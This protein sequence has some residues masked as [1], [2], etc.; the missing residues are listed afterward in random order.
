MTGQPV[1]VVIVDDSQY[2]RRMFEQFLSADPAIEVVGSAADPLEARELI[3]AT[4]PDVV[5]LDVEMP[6][7]DGLSFLKK[8]MALRP[9]PVV[10]VSSLTQ[11]GAETTLKALEAGAVDYIGKP[12]TAKEL[13][14]IRS[15]L[16][17]KVKTAARVDVRAKARKAATAAPP[18]TLSYTGDASKWLIAIGASTGG[19]EAIREI[20]EAMPAM[21]PPMIITQHMPPMFT[22]SFAKRLNGLVAPTV[23]EAKEGQP[24][25]PGHVYIAPGAHH[26]SL[27]KQAGG[28]VCRL[29]D[30]P[31]VSGHKPS[32]DVMF[33]AVAET[34][35][36]RAVAAIL[37]GMGRDGAAGITKLHALGV[38]TLG[39]N[40]ASC[41]VY[42]MPRAAQ[43]MGGLRKELHLDRIAA[44]LLSL[45]A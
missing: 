11:K 33:E 3:K 9:M 30:R 45:C 13:E 43:A 2:I 5:T 8:I 19:V 37:T 35:P 41:I 32:V 6:K 1:K 44:E 42:G 26:L 18:K 34:C 23:C 36:Q 29:D 20:L 14:A 12:S 17:R 25:R 38:P 4:N 22:D 21:I 39:Q 16:V 31:E 10:M 27:R 24:L 40:E 7:M 15:E 28:L